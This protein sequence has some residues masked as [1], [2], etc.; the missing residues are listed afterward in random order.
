MTLAGRGRS[1]ISGP[2]PLKML[3]CALWEAQGLVWD[4]GGVSR[5]AEADPVDED[6]DRVVCG[7]AE[8]VASGLEGFAESSGCSGAARFAQEQ[9]QVEGADVDEQAF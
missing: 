5:C 3:R 7:R 1:L 8:G 4:L 9:T 6:A 2:T